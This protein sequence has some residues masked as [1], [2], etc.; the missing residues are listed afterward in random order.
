[1]MDRRGALKKLRDLG[2]V[3][4]VDGCEESYQYEEDLI[5]YIVENIEFKEIKGLVDLEML[6]RVIIR[7]LIRL[8]I[9]QSRQYRGEYT[10]KFEDLLYRL[11]VMGYV[12]YLEPSVY[13]KYMTE[14]SR[15]RG[16]EVL[17]IVANNLYRWVTDPEEEEDIIKRKLM[18]KIKVVDFVRM[19]HQIMDC[20]TV[21]GIH[22]REIKTLEF[23]WEIVK[24]R[25][26]KM[27]M[28]GGYDDQVLDYLH[29]PTIHTYKKLVENVGSPYVY[30]EVDLI[31]KVSIKDYDDI[32]KKVFGSLKKE[33]M[34]VIKSI[35]DK[36]I[37][38]EVVFL[39]SV[40]VDVLKET[41]RLSVVRMLAE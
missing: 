31:S 21:G 38:K 22:M 8:Q 41:S 12:P 27:K 29:Q 34:S 10:R 28:F 3:T 7:V 37:D 40:G 25:S 9:K 19:Y 26:R 2:D 4:I 13:F 23:T 17:N 15:L 36:N 14:Y 39:R 16:V 20:Y 35:V 24:G 5:M 11:A 6:E 32:R 18:F 33:D 1:M 30:E